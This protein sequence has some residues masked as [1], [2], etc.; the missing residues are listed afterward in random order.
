M[1]AGGCAGVIR[2]AFYTY[3]GVFQLC[4]SD[5]YHFVKA[6]GVSVDIGAETDL[7]RYPGVT[8]P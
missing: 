6:I 5:K 7:C 3:V 1:P 2:Q 8:V 4:A